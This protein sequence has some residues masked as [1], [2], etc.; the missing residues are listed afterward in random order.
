[1]VFCK[2]LIFNEIC[3][4]ER[5]IRT[6]GISSETPIIKAFLNK[7]GQET[8]K[9]DKKRQIKHYSKTDNYTELVCLFALTRWTHYLLRH[10]HHLLWHFHVF[11]EKCEAGG[12]DYHANKKVN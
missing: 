9:T 5:G 12:G 8:D 10:G 6:R 2:S 3:G 7:N 4:G 1:M 11:R